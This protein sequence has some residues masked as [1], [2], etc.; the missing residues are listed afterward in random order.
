MKTREQAREELKEFKESLKVGFFVLPASYLAIW[1]LP[2]TVLGDWLESLW[3][4]KRVEAYEGW[5]LLFGSI[6]AGL[7]LLRPLYWLVTTAYIAVRG[8]ASH[9]KRMPTS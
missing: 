4:S 5:I 3:I 8:R 9:D 7:I 6:G 1:L 2:K